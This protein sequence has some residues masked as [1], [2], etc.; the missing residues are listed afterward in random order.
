LLERVTRRVREGS[1]SRASAPAAAAAAMAAAAQAVSPPATGM[2]ATGTHATVT[3]APAVIENAA[4]PAALLTRE[5]CLARAERALQAKTLSGGVAQVIALA[6]SP[7]SDLAQLAETIARDAV[8]STK[9]LQAANSAAYASNRGMITSISEAVR[10][11][12]CSTVSNIAT[13]V[14]VF[15][16]MPDTGPDGFNPIRC[17]QHSFAVAKLCE[18]LARPQ[19]PQQAGAAYLA[20]L[21]HDLGEILFRTHFGAEYTKVLEAHRTA[22]KPLRQL[23]RDMLGITQE[24]L[25]MIILRCL[26]LP[27]SIRKPIEEVHAEGE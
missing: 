12:G 2:P 21:C 8:L 1:A 18:H 10:R 24:E 11:I 25:S 15:E 7:N 9:V 13:T 3:P 4:Q 22:A 17:W 6:T 5:A 23:E 27:E 26:K 14:G 20:G 19:F 16:A